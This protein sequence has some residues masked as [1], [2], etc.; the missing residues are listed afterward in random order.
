MKTRRIDPYARPSPQDDIFNLFRQGVHGI[1]I[2]AEHFK[3]S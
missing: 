1:Y 3:F 2:E